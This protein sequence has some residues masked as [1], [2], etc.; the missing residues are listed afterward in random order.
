M[1]PK[2]TGAAERLRIREYFEDELG[3]MRPGALFDPNDV[4]EL[5]ERIQDIN[6]LRT[7]SW[8]VEKFREW[9]DS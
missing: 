8:V 4:R 5:S 2:K 3:R 7:L 1:K 9:G 6:S